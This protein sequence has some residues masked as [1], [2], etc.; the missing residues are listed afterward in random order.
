MNLNYMKQIL[1]FLAITVL[2]VSCSN[3]RLILEKFPTEMPTMP[4]PVKTQLSTENP[5][6]SPTW[7]PSPSPQ[8]TLS[9]E[10]AGKITYDLINDNFDCRLP[11]W[12]NTEFGISTWIDVLNEI[13]NISRNILQSPTSRISENGDWT[14]YTSFLVHFIVQGQEELGR[15]EFFLENGIVTSAIVYQVGTADSFNLQKLFEDYGVPSEIRLSKSY[16][17]DSGE[18]RF[19]LLV[20]YAE[21]RIVA[22]YESFRNESADIS[23]YCPQSI[24]PK[25]YLGNFEVIDFWPQY[26]EVTSP[27]EEVFGLNTTEFYDFFVSTSQADCVKFLIPL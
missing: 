1:F 4:L 10:I 20:I 23:F 5:P 25:L 8:V 13:G 21:E 18:I 17:S 7:T 11:C 15:T 6:L 14:E 22:L 2:I 26:A 9:D 19:T 24:G 3:S 27:L 12:L 16:L